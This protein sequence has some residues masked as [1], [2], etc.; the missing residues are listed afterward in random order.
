M[1]IWTQNGRNKR[2]LEK[3]V[4]EELRDLYYASQYYLI[5]VTKQ[6][7]REERGTF[8]VVWQEKRRWGFGWK[9]LQQGDHLED[10]GV[11]ENMIL[12]EVDWINLTQ[13]TNKGPAAVNTVTTLLFL[14]S[15]L[16]FLTDWGPNNL[17]RRAVIRGVTQLP[18][19]N[20]SVYHCLLKSPLLVPT[21]KQ[22]NPVHALPPN[23]FK[24]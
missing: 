16:T 11:Y 20:S 24:I 17:S 13:N 6:Q 7:G 1:E 9:N 18:L 4:C 10:P 15:S 22:I 19:W 23:F 21:L 12:E 5:Q 14:W 3:T 2:G 8:R